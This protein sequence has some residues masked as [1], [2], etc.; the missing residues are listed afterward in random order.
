MSSGYLRIGCSQVVQRAVSALGVLEVLNEVG[1]G[2]RGSASVRGPIRLD[3]FE[4]MGRDYEPLNLTRRP[5]L[6][7]FENS[8]H[9]SN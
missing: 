7:R 5:Q 8:K 2:D 4:S 3:D 1:H 9:P 6:L